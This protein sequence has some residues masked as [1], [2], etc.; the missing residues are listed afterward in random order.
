MP[1]LANLMMNAW[2]GNGHEGAM[3]QGGVNDRES[4]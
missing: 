4:C 3:D 1:V 2:I